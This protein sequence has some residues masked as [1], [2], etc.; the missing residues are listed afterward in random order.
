MCQYSAVDGVPGTWHQV[1][2]GSFATGGAGLIFAEASGVVAE[3]RI[4]T[5]CPGLWNDEQVEAWRRVTDFAHSQGAHMGIQLAH[6]GRKASTLA[7]W[8]DHLMA[9]E[10]EGGWRAVAPSPLAFEGYPVPHALVAN[11][12]ASL[13]EAFGHAAKRAVAA[14]FDVVEIHAAHGYLL[15]EF[16][17]P[18][19][20]QREDQYG[21]SFDNRIRMALEV[22]D[23]VR[24][25]IPDAMPLFARISAT[26]YVDGGWDLEQSIELSTAMKSRGVDLVDVSSGGNVHWVRIPV[27][28][29]YQ[30]PVASAIRRSAG[31]ATS[32]VGLITDPQQADGIVARG[33]ADAVMMA[34]ELLRQPRWAL[35]A[36]E[37]LGEVIDWPRQ[38][39]RARQLRS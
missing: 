15:H 17:S 10:S 25:C 12:I 2:L 9:S 38:F 29:G 31:I 36:A 37:T 18:L 26:D 20:N 1:H 14:G 34:R 28:P 16:M 22:V 3:G 6:A 21:G 13:V 5:K 30:G 7:P 11:E 39:D 4:S 35:S 23:R 19:S 8:D 24:S 32:A 27:A 33:D